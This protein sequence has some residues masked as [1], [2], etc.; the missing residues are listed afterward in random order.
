MGYFGWRAVLWGSGCGGIIGSPIG[1]GEGGAR[2]LIW[3]EEIET[4]KESEE[5]NK[6]SNR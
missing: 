1:K 4:G 5:K 6:S 2:S 3:N